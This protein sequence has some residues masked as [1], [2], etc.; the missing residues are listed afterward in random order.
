MVI[1]LLVALNRGKA[2]PTSSF[3]HSTGPK[4]NWVM[5]KPERTDADPVFERH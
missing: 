4:M 5:E 1:L 3:E 2:S